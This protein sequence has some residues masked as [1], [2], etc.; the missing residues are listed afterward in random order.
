MKISYQNDVVTVFESELM[1]TTCTLVE[2][3]DHLLLVDPNWL[4]SEV[5]FIAKE[6]ERK[7]GDRDLYLLFTHS[8]Y[9]HII[10]YE[11]FRDH[12][13]LIVSEAFMKN[14]QKEEQLQEI[15]KFYDQYYL[16][17]PW[18]ITYPG[19]AT[20]QIS[21]TTEEHQI[22]Q[23]RYRF[24]QA[25]G[26]NPDGIITY[27]PDSGILIVGDYL[28]AV[29]FPF[30]YHSIEA[31]LLSLS[32]LDALLVQEDVKLLVSGHGP[33]TTDDREMKDRWQSSYEYLVK[34]K[35]Y[36]ESGGHFDDDEL[37]RTYRHFPII[38]RKYHE[39][40]LRLAEKE[41]RN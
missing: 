21:Q 31:Y 37:W 12:A 20:L 4:P 30:V 9:D 14:S 40:N 35:A 38:Q 15:R 24:I 19:S 41:Y 8:D 6:V 28:S 26:H 25:A 18:P 3:A 2:Q 23:T 22:G 17:P 29:E 34:L 10:G 16:K 7:R 13:K 5:E 27:L 11:R 1:A 36:G 39:E 32:R 33:V